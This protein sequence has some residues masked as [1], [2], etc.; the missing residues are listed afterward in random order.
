MIICVEKGFAI[1]DVNEVSSEFNRNL[2][3][4]APVQESSAAYHFES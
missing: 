3:T 1:N 2:L 4:C